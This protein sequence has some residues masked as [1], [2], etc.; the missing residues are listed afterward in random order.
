MFDFM[1]F[2]GLNKDKSFIIDNKLDKRF[3]NVIFYDID[4]NTFIN[5]SNERNL[6]LASSLS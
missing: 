4:E 6:K 3:P 5:K 2:S 1:T